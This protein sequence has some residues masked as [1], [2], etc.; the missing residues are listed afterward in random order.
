M[1]ATAA[2]TVI[3]KLFTYWVFKQQ[4]W[5]MAEK[6]K[7]TAELQL[8]KAQIHPHFLFNTLNNIY[9][10]SLHNSSKTPG[11]ILNLSSLLH[12][13]L[14]D[15]KAEQVAL[16]KEV[17]IMRNY[18]DLEKERYGNKIEISW[19]LEGDIIDEFISPLILLPFIENAFKHGTSEQLEKPWLSV[20][21]SVSGHRLFTKIVNSKNSFV[22]ISENGIGIKN[23]RKRLELL[24]PNRHELIMNDEESFFAVTLI[25]SLRENNSPTNIVKKRQFEIEN[26]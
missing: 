2:G 1:V 14:Y 17:N 4:Q 22:P 9:S 20:D 16:E 3:L 12:Y 13:M 10:F 6:E 8:L 18:I 21:I 7:M 24:Y 11:L 26:A 15:C 25:L 19:S 23:V 5:L